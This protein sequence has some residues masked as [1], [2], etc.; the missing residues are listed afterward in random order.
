MSQNYTFV[1][2]HD[3]NNQTMRPSIPHVATTPKQDAE[4]F[5]FPTEMNETGEFTFQGV[6]PLSVFF[7]RQTELH[8]LTVEYCIELVVI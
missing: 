5:F 3:Q 4:L 7:C 8:T 6:D 1:P 2:S